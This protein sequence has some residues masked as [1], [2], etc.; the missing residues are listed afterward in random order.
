MVGS[1]IV[2]TMDPSTTDAHPDRPHDHAVAPPSRLPVTSYPRVL[3]TGFAMGSADI[4]PGVSGG[5]VALVLGIYDRLVGAVRQGTRGLA[6]LLR[7]RP[8]DAWQALIAVDWGFLLVLLGGIATAVVL[9]AGVLEQLLEEQ[10]VLLSAA[11]LGLVAGSVVVAADEV[12]EVTPRTW[13]I[14]TVTAVAT[15]LLL[16]LRAGTLQDPSLLVL[17][18]GGALAICAMILPGVSGSF[19]LLLVGLYEVVLAAVDDRDLATLAAVGIGAVVGLALFS[20]LLHWLLDHHRNTVMAALLGLMVGACGDDSAER[21][22]DLEAELDSRRT[23][24]ALALACRRGRRRRHPVGCARRAG[25]RRARAGRRRRAARG[26]RRPARPT[27]G[28]LRA[29]SPVGHRRRSPRPRQRRPRGR[30]RRSAPAPAAASPRRPA[31]RPH[32]ATR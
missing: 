20:T 8:R 13:A 1:R 24:G 21:I 29:V 22:A 15:F 4:V 17:V 14:G 3:A 23:A 26:R 10:P 18:A 30:R 5:T 7:G 32:P 9:L 16:G 6:A 25:A 31:R 2:R 11:F 27:R 28:P 12:E 19:L